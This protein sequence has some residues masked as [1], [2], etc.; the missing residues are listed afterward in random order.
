MLGINV[1]GREVVIC[2]L[3]MC[4]LY[5]DELMIVRVADMEELDRG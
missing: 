4:V 2:F 3:Y 1:G 5:I